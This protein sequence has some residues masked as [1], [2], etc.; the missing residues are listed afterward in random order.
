M[1]KVLTNNILGIVII[2]YI[3][4]VVKWESNLEYWNYLKQSLANDH[5][6]SFSRKLHLRL[7][8]NYYGK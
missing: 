5:S 7:F 8:Y 2:I 6:C 4:K 1:Q 3:L